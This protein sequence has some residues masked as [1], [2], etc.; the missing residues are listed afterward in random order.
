MAHR[1]EGGVEQSQNHGYRERQ[2]DRQAAHGAHL[3][4]ELAAVVKPV[5]GGQGDGF[6]DAGLGIGDDTTQVPAPDVELHH[7]ALLAVFALDDL[8]A[9]LARNGRDLAEAHLLAAGGVQHEVAHALG[10]GPVAGRKAQHERIAT[11]SFHELGHVKPAGGRINDIAE[12]GD[13][14]AVAGELIAA[15]LD[16]QF[17]DALGELH[18]QIG[19]A[20]HRADRGLDAVSDF[21][22]LGRVVTKDLDG[23]IRFDP[24]DGLIHAHGHR[25]GEV[26]LHTGHG[27]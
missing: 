11:L 23:H 26:E 1:R 4:L 9:L 10:I 27:L 6:V 20:G 7:Q 15:G 14:E 25:H 13:G 24:R 12:V 16:A 22:E 5:A 8:G 21:G 18:L 3:I 19:D 17:A 2:H